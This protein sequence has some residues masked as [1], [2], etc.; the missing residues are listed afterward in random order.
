LTLAGPNVTYR[1]FRF[2][3]HGA[4]TTSPDLVVETEGKSRVLYFSWNGA[5]EV[6][7]Y[8]LFG[9]SSEE[10]LSLLATKTKTGFE[11]TH[12]IADPLLIQC[13]YQVV[14]LDHQG[15]AMTASEVVYSGAPCNHAQ[16]LPMVVSP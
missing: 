12:T 6:A 9:G 11:T 16:F 10:N 1:A 13:Y 14:P 8:R 7:S 3:W 5:T 2:P 4:P 15:N